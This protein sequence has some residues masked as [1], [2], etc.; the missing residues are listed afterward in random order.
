MA[1]LN[2]HISNKLPTQAFH[3]LSCFDGEM[4]EGG[5]RSVCEIPPVGLDVSGIIAYDFCGLK[6]SNSL[7][8]ECFE[9]RSG[10]WSGNRTPI[11]V[12]IGPAIGHVRAC[13]SRR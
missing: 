1:A 7:T 5:G 11:P 9:K 2:R 12:A 8:W 13:H 3:E 10:Y 6:D 4:G